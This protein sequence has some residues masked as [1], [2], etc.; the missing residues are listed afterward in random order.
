MSNAYKLQVENIKAVKSR[1]QMLSPPPF[2]N[3]NLIKPQNKE[4]TLKVI[5]PQ[6]EKKKKHKRDIMILSDKIIKTNDEDTWKSTTKKIKKLV[7]LVYNIE[8]IELSGRRR[9]KH[10][11]N[12]RHTAFYLMARFTSKSYPQIGKLLGGFDHTSV[13]HGANRIK[14]LV[15]DPSNDCDKIK[16]LIKQIEKFSQAN[17]SRD[18]ND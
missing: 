18:Y 14:N 9:Q 10:L 7:C 16:F 4:K 17:P 11:V 13:L 8:Y 2:V 3:M 12:A 1:L 15:S 6:L 5:L